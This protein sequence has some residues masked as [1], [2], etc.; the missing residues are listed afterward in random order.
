MSGAE[1]SIAGCDR[2]IFARGWCV[3]H[4]NRW[5]RCGTTHPEIPIH[6]RSAPP[7]MPDRAPTPVYVLC[8]EDLLPL[9]AEVV[10]NDARAI[11][12]HMW[13]VIGEWHLAGILDKET[14]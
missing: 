13:A 4:Y 1:C 12:R 9:V 7:T 14:A 8:P 5:R 2:K 6:G 11:F 10:E 3:A